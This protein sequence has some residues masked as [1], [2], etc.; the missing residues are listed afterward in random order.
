VQNLCRRDSKGG[1]PVDYFQSLVLLVVL[2]IL[3][4]IGRRR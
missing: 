2:V 3:V 1:S 4:M